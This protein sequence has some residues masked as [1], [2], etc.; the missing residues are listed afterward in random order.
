MNC[1]FATP[2][3]TLTDGFGSVESAPRRRQCSYHQ[4]N[5][6]TPSSRMEVQPARNRPSSKSAIR[7]QSQTESSYFVMVC[8]MRLDVVVQNMW[9]GESKQRPEVHLKKKF[10]RCWVICPLPN[11]WMRNYAVIEHGKRRMEIVWFSPFPFRTPSQFMA[12]NGWG[13][14]QTSPANGS[15]HPVLVRHALDL[16]HKRAAGRVMKNPSPTTNFVNSWNHFIKEV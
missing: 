9:D 13:Q 12:E 1:Q 10:H 16:M 7:E 5:F 14:L 11:F 15:T 2:S 3:L 4:T 6:R 8:S